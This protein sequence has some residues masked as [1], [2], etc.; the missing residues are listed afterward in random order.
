MSAL[1]ISLTVFDEILVGQP[2]DNKLERIRQKIH[3]G[4]AKGFWMHEDDS[5][6]YKGHWCVP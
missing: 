3:D 2:G 6:G 4:R 5:I 1:S